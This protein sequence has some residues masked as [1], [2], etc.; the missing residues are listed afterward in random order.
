MKIDSKCLASALKKTRYA[1]A[2]QT[3]EKSGEKKLLC[4]SFWENIE[5]VAYSWWMNRCVWLQ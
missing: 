1:V 4:N 2:V 3:N 5:N